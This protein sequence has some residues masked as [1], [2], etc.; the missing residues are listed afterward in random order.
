VDI[1]ST[2]IPA[3]GRGF[4]EV[5]LA[6]EPIDADDPFLYHKTTNRRV[7]ERALA[8]RP[9]AS[10]VLLFNERH[11]LTESTI[12]NLI[13]HLDGSLVTP[14][15]Q[16]GL[17]PGTARARL[18][19]QGKVRERVIAVDELSFAGGLWLVNSVRGMHEIS[20]LGGLTV[21]SGGVPSL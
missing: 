13:V 16:C 20:R 14:P 21:S 7:Y 3:D 19:E 18:L 12:A 5:Q 2:S 4:G 15:V 17:L 8:S 9:G 1:T 10:D 11:E 6:A